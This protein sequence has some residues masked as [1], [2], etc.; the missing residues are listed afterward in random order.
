MSAG[1]VIA[2]GGLAGQRCAETLRRSGYDGPIRMVC[3]EPHRPYDRPPL[4]KAALADA[5]GD[6]QVAFRPAGWYAD[7]AVE[8]RLGVPVT[9]LDPA[10]RVVEL[11]DDESLRYDKL[12]IATGSVPRPLPLLE[13]Y[14]N[15][16]TLRTVEDAR[17][18]R[19]VLARGGHVV[20]VGAGFIGQEVA[21]AARRAGVR[22]TVIEAAPAPLEPVLGAALGHWFAALHR[23]EGVDVVLG[24]QV[25]AANG[26]HRVESLVLD[27]DRRLDCD[28]VVVGIGVRPALDW[29]RGS[30]L[31]PAGVRVDGDGRAAAPDVYAAGDAAAAFDSVAGRHVAGGHWESAARQGARTAKAMLGLAPGAPSLSGFW[32]D[33]YGT[34]VHYLGRALPHH[35]DLRIDGNPLLRDFTATFVRAGRP[36]AALLVGRPHALPAARALLAA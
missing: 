23:E 29:L 26:D 22:V 24:R 28:H 32:S 20:I 2:G 7:H 6:D 8:L 1:V 10:R 30:G 16:T 35:D 19:G 11:G 4:S 14:A 17:G 9:R 33:L 3:G 21:A 12:V 27:D 25:V 15:V 13:R 5:L 18:L 31:D 34:R 36:V